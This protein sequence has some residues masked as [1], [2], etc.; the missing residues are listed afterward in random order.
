M[1]KLPHWIFPTY[2]GLAGRTKEIRLAEYY[3]TGYDL[4]SRLLDLRKDELDE[5]EY[6]IQTIE[7]DYKYDKISKSVYKTK[8]AHLIEDPKSKEL[9]LLEIAKEDNTITDL[10]YEKAVATIKN[11]PWVKVLKLS[12]SS[13][14]TLEGGFDLD[15]NDVFVEKLRAEGYNGI[16]DE[17]VVNTWFMEVCRNVAMDEFDG[18]GEFSSD[19]QANLDAVKRWNQTTVETTD[20]SGKRIYK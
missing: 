19:S 7:L 8:L 4:E 12:V 16:D 9:A 18:Q 11:E 2:W 5:K 3:L 13:K 10:Q 14:T 20:T 6:I 17:R 1:K 15:W